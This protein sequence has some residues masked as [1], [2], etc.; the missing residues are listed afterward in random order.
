MKRFLKLL[1][2]LTLISNFK[3][4]GLEKNSKIKGIMFENRQFFE[5]IES[6]N[7]QKTYYIPRQETIAN[8][9]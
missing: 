1:I 5:F 7:V 2:S 6:P 4:N 9:C 8:F 3:I